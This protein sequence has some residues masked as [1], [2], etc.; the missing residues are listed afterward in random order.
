[1]ISKGH[2]LGNKQAPG[3]RSQSHRRPASG[4]TG[5]YAVLNRVK[6]GS[7]TLLTSEAAGETE[8]LLDQFR[9]LYPGAAVR[10]VASTHRHLPPV[11]Q[12]VALGRDTYDHCW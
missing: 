4:G 2:A 3:D 5:I 12:R 11:D 7:Q 8:E 1:M 9:I 10:F 6:I